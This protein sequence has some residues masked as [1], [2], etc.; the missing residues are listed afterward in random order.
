MTTQTVAFP[1]V[2]DLDIDD[3]KQVLRG[4]CRA[5]RKA[6]S[7]GRIDQAAEDYAQTVRDFVGNAHRVACYVSVNNEPSTRMVLRELAAMGT[8]IYLPKLGPGLQRAWGIY[9]G[10]DD[11]QVAA[12][13]RP[14]EPSGETFTNDILDTIEVMI[15]PALLVGADGARLGQGGGWYDRA[16]KHTSPSTRVGALLYPDEFVD[17]ALPR[18]EMDVAVGYAILPREVIAT[19]AAK[20]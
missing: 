14:P 7:Q 9:R 3:A 1:H 17:F 12:P 18:D 5:R 13:G 6:R 16:L 19:S 15:V 4:T 11:L 8:E 20:A 2:A 10:D